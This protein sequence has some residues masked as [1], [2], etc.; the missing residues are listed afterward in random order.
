MG[1]IEE[2]CASCLEALRYNRSFKIYFQYFK[3]PDDGVA[4]LNSLVGR[5]LPENKI[6]EERQ[7]D[8]RASLIAVFRQN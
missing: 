5:N 6:M 4:L 1:A 2:Y 7:E 8:K 3:K